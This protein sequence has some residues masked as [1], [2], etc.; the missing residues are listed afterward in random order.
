MPPPKAG[1]SLTVLEGQGF[2][3]DW[4]YGFDPA[5]DVTGAANQ[6]FFDAVYGQLFDL[7][8]NG[9]IVPDLA[10]GYKF[11]PDAKTVT[12]TLRQGVKFSDG[13]P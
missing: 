2:A 5:T 6:D 11:S 8:A 9:K 10:T 7:G 1:G 4:P 12:V 13:T 3:G